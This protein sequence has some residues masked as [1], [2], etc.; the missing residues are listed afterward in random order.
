MRGIEISR[1]YYL[2]VVRPFLDRAAPGL[3]HAAALAGGGSELLGFDDETSRDHDWGPRVHIYL[4][5]PDFDA[6]ARLLLAAFSKVSPDTF[7]GQPSAWRG[8]TQNAPDT[9]EAIGDNRHGLELHTL[10]S[11]LER[12][13]GQRTLESVTFVDWLG[14]PAQKL[15]AFTTGAVFRD[16]DGR[17]TAAREKLTYYPEDVWLYKIAC[18]WRRIAEEQAFVGRAG[19]VGD[20]LGSRL[21]AARMVREVM[22]L[23]F[24]LERQ[25]APYAKWL[26][27]AFSR[28]SIATVLAPHME[29]T[30]R[31]E[32]WQGRAA[33][34][35]ELYR[36][37]GQWQVDRGIARFAPRIRPYFERPFP[38]INAEDAVASAMAAISDPALRALPVIGAIDQISDSTPL[39]VDAGLTRQMIAG[40]LGKERLH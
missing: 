32:E 38:T 15:L 10:E 33:A 5:G 31:G 22:E 28:L 11:T 14:F 7:L 30:L 39:L 8:R 18:Q 23:G 26:G 21:I 1:R 16:D 40:V 35:A 25:Y 20:D 29:A 13:F 12:Q 36:E 3:S 19:Q 27:A 4:A 34:L 2:E 9:V 24:L 6:H 17:L 37:V